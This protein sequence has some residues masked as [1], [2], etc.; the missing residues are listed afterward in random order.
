MRKSSRPSRH[1]RG[2]RTR[3]SICLM[4]IA[5]SLFPSAIDFA[6]C[7]PIPRTK[8]SEQLYGR[9]TI[10]IGC[11]SYHPPTCVARC[12]RFHAIC[13]FTM[14]RIVEKFVASSISSVND[15]AYETTPPSPGRRTTFAALSDP[16]PLRRLYC[17][18][19]SCGTDTSSKSC[20][21]RSDSFRHT[22]SMV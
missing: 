15:I 13:S 2:S 14:F 21:F 11:G 1:P 12:T 10:Y 20:R 8:K 3:S 18:H 9:D 6:E 22:N 19:N 4:T 16:R 17:S 5:G 7:F